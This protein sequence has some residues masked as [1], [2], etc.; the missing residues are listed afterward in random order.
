VRLLYRLWLSMPN[1][2]PLPSGHEVLWGSIAPG[3]LRGGIG[4]VPTA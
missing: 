2:R 3:A 4:Q 1:S